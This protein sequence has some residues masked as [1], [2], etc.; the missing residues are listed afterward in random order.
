MLPITMSEVESA[1]IP[2]VV[3]WLKGVCF[4]TSVGFFT[5]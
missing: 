3:L 1:V 4:Q 2:V 5:T